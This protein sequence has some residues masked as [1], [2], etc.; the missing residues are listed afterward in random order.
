VKI[1]PREGSL[2][3]SQIAVFSN[4]IDRH[5][6]NKYCTSEEQHCQKKVLSFFIDKN[7]SEW[8]KT[9]FA[10]THIRELNMML[11]NTDLTQGLR[12]RSSNILRTPSMH[13]T[14]MDENS[15]SLRR[16][17][18]N[19]KGLSESRSK[20]SVKI[21]SSSAIR[22]RRAFGDISNQ[23]SSRTNYSGNPNSAFP[24]KT[25]VSLTLKKPKSVSFQSEKSGKIRSQ[26]IKSKSRESLRELKAK[27]PKSITKTPKSKAA[28][29]IPTDA[30]LR[31]ESMQKQVNTRKNLKNSASTKKNRIS[32]KPSEPY[33]D[34]ER[35][36]GRMW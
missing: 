13:M 29:E 35:S 22:T 2:S 11:N 25:S 5:F 28:F 21:K 30:S 24:K 23:D 20:S 26:K 14:P 8:Y 3:S 36:A 27:T 1:I 4:S 12:T 17:K 33:E 7:T 31:F 34:I 32:A 18:K 15:M 10:E 6:R 9:I 16:S 19:G